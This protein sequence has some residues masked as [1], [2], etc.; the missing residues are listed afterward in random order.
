[1][2]LKCM[3]NLELKFEISY[4]ITKFCH[5]NTVIFRKLPY[6][7]NEV[8]LFENHPHSPLGTFLWLLSLLLF[9]LCY[10]FLYNYTVSLH[11][12]SHYIVA[13]VNQIRDHKELIYPY[14][15]NDLGV[16]GHSYS[17]FQDNNITNKLPIKVIFNALWSCF[18]IYWRDDVL[19]CSMVNIWGTFFIQ[20]IFVFD[21]KSFF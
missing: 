11:D 5:A 8:L 20:R 2:K 17:D 3:Q 12:V 4:W 18:F 19:F 21:R 13:G 7:S 14:S 10:F 6:E 1:M 16:S 9:T 15:S